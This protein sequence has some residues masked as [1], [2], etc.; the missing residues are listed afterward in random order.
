MREELDKTLCESYPLIFRGRNGRARR[1][2]TSWGI[3]GGDG[4]YDLV[5]ALC[6]LIYW[7]Y[8]QA[9]D[10][11]T[12]ARSE[13]GVVGRNGEAQYTAVDVERLRL[14][15]RDEAARIPAAIEVK[16]KLGGLRFYIQPGADEDKSRLERIHAYIDFAEYMSTRICDVCGSPGKQ[17]GSGWIRTLCGKHREEHENGNKR[18]EP[19]KPRNVRLFDMPGI[20]PLSFIVGEPI[21]H[22]HNRELAALARPLVERFN[23]EDAKS[24]TGHCEDGRTVEDNLIDAMTALGFIKPVTVVSPFHWDEDIGPELTAGTGG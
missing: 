2:G 13:E 11:Y 19:R 4:W 1:P 22:L 10:S 9:V 7:P 18:T 16:A 6:G 5:D 23:A 3:G 20:V 17:G 14:K 8:Q 24:E 21:E 12:Y 15:M